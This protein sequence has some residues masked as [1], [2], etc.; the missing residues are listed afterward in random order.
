MTTLQGR[1]HAPLGLAQGLLDEQRHGADL[2]AQEVDE[3]TFSALNEFEWL[4]EHME[5]V[6]TRAQLYDY[7]RCY[8]M[9]A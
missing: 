2:A 7:N 8:R 9:A 5:E 3:F 4:N 1:G 6:F